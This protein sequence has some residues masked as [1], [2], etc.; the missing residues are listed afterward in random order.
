MTDRVAVLGD[1]AGGHLAACL[2]TIGGFDD[3]KDDLSI[4]AAA[5]AMVLYNPIV[6]LTVEGNKWYYAVD[7][8]VAGGVGFGGTDAQSVCGGV[9]TFADF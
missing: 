6:D 8:A 7:R 5:N 2:G 1:S 9:R 3:P 4:S